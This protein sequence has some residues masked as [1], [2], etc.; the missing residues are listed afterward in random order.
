[1]LSYLYEDM[2]SLA[3]G[4][5]ILSTV[6][7][8]SHSCTAVVSYPQDAH[9]H[10]AVIPSDI[11]VITVLSGRASSSKLIGASATG[12]EREVAGSAASMYASSNGLSRLSTH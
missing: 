5:I 11:E 3:I 1:M 6:Y 9:D 12:A 8:Q 10:D 2:N 7:L 4:L